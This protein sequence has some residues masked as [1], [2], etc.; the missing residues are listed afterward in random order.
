ME[1]SVIGERRPQAAR[2]GWKAWM[3]VGLMA[4]AANVL[5]L[6]NPGFFSHD[7][8]QKYDHLREKGVA[9]FVA[10]YGQ[11]RVGPD[12]G[13]PVRPI[14]FLQQG[15]SASFMAD[16][17]FVAHA[18]DVLMHV[19]CALL[20]LAALSRTPLRGRWANLIAVVFAISPL[21]TFSTGWVGAS[22]DRWYVLFGLV[23][24]IGVIG[25][26]YDRLSLSNVLLIVGGTA[27]ATL[28]K[29]TS[30]MLPVAVLLVQLALLLKGHARLDLRRGT[31]ILALV[32]LPIVVYL[33]FR[34]PALIASFSG[35]AG[36]YDPG[37]GDLL[38]NV[39]LYFAQPFMIDAV[40]LIS[41]GNL[42]QWQWMMALGMHAA[43]V[44]V[45]AWR[46]GVL[47]ALLYLAAYFLFLLPV[48][49]V[50]IV[51]AH[52]LYASGVA[53]SIG[54][55]AAFFPDCRSRFGRALAILAFVC[56]LTVACY[57][58][59]TIQRNL[60]VAGICQVVLLS[61][62]DAQIE[63]ARKQGETS[64]WVVPEFGAPGYI[65]VRSTFARWP[66]EAQHGMQVGIGEPEAAPSNGAR[67]LVM[68]PD[69]RIVSR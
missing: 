17:P 52:Y 47:A 54:L 65:A 9:D 49:P 4:I 21:A 43:M 51:G 22:F 15:L 55:V 38:G 44:V 35:H 25:A 61:D 59:Y 60:Q 41:A 68:K 26:T 37:R 6:V 67:M 24:A 16:Q 50:P 42:P 29:E 33:L 40:E 2:V 13:F 63:A 46:R 18:I 56:Y 53:F 23:T 30:V 62:I 28:T 32:S 8:W 12:F 34:M 36:A 64:L 7:E 11:L 5:T 57:H 3:L 19:V 31:M 66:Y 27:G 1:P 48:M 20:L 58:A 39:R 14:G 10:E 69:C 45:L